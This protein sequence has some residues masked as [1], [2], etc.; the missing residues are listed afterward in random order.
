MNVRQDVGIVFENFQDQQLE[1]IVVVNN[2]VHFILQLIQH[3]IKHRM[4]VR[5]FHSLS[6][7]NHFTLLLFQTSHTFAQLLPYL[8]LFLIS[9]IGTF[10]VSEPQFQL[11]RTG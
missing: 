9:I 8:F 2:K 3:N 7:S 5:T 4:F 10:L 11:H 1:L 6:L